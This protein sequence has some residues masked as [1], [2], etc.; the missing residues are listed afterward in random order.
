MDMR[1]LL[2]DD[3][4]MEV[5]SCDSAS[6]F[7]GF[8]CGNTTI[9]SYFREKAVVDANNVCYAYRCTATGDI[10]GL[11]TLCCSGINI[12]S[13]N[14]VKLIPAIK[15]DYFAISEQYQNILF[16]GSQRE[17]H[18]YISDA[19]LSNLIN[20]VRSISALY[21]GATYMILY[22]VPDAIHLYERNGFERF[23]E[24]MKAENERF[25]E[26]CTPMYLPLDH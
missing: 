10:V 21:V 20:E 5:V 3:F 23:Q 14:L 22:S 8:S 1:Q 17:D 2:P 6:I 11:A 16:P 9:D 12:N 15:M 4:S 18:F 25:L 19:F 13:G 26:G 7:S 24:F